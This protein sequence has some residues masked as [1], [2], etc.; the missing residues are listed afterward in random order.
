MGIETPAVKVPA[1]AAM[2]VKA[3]ETK[4]NTK[5]HDIFPKLGSNRQP[6]YFI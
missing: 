4:I 3:G 1:E 5:S 2:E 6:L